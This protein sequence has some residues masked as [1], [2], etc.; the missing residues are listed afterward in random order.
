MRHDARQ[1]H[2]SQQVTWRGVLSFD[3]P[4]AGLA[5]SGSRSSRPG[6][7]LKLIRT[8]HSCW[9]AHKASPTPDIIARFVLFWP[10]KSAQQACASDN[11]AHAG[12]SSVIGCEREVQ[13]KA[14]PGKRGGTRIRLPSCGP[15]SS[16]LHIVGDV[17]FRYGAACTICDASA[18]SSGS[19]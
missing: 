5:P 12:A 14:V 19:R 8:R 6:S 18:G 9:A 2:R 3:L 11:H 7:W 1:G 16:Q 4:H 13:L 17:Q 15:R 10:A